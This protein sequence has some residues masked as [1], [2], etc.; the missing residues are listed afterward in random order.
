M[1]SAV[2]PLVLVFI[3]DHYIFILDDS[4]DRYRWLK[5]GSEQLSGDSGAVKVA[6]PKLYLA[7]VE[8]L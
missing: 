6:S 3:D 1:S 4:A 5:G 2:R 7:G 8:K